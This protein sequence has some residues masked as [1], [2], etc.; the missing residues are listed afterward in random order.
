MAVDMAQEI[1]GTEENMNLNKS[2]QEWINEVIRPVNE[3][4]N[5]TMKPSN[6][7]SSSSS[8]VSV[9]RL[10]AKLRTVSV[11]EPLTGRQDNGLT[12]NVSSPIAS[13]YQEIRRPGLGLAI[14]NP[15]ARAD[16]LNSVMVNN[17]QGAGRT[18]EQLSLG[19]VGQKLHSSNL[20]NNQGV[21]ITQ[22]R[23][24][25]MQTGLDVFDSQIGIAI[26]D[27][28]GG[29][30]PLLDQLQHHKRWNTGA[31]NTGF[32]ETNTGIDGNSFLVHSVM[33]PFIKDYNTAAARLSNPLKSTSVSS[34]DAPGECSNPTREIKAKESRFT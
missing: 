23:G 28:I 10:T 5:S 13:G 27:D 31:L 15:I 8:A 2:I 29:G 11:V 32:A 30:Q 34:P 21:F 4:L 25:I 20:F 7:T 14:V 6:R 17:H 16:D 12:N 24:G 19:E 1:E 26:L 33:P 18:I 9:N 22:D 3:S